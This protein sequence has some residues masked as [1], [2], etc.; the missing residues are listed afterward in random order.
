MPKNLFATLLI[1]PSEKALERIG[2]ISGALQRPIM[3][4]L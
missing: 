4:K 1:P 3:K 2:T